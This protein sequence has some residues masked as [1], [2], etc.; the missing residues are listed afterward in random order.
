M[1]FEAC[2]LVFNFDVAVYHVLVFIPDDHRSSLT[3]TH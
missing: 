3:V 1:E 2:D